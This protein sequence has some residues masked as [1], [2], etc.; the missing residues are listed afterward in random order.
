MDGQ[1]KNF[2]VFVQM[3]KFYHGKCGGIVKPTAAHKALGMNHHALVYACYRK[4]KLL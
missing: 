4:P 2:T 3:V 1:E